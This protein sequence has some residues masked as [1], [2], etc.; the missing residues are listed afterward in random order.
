MRMTIN[1]EDIETRWLEIRNFRNLGPFC[2]SGKPKANDDKAFVKMNRAL[3]YDVLGGLI[4][5]IGVNNSGKSNVL[6]AFDCYRTQEFKDSDF[7]DFTLVDKPPKPYVGINL[8]N[9]KYRTV[10]EKEPVEYHGQWNATLFAFLLELDNYE[11]YQDYVDDENKTY[12]D[13]LEYLK[14]IV[15]PTFSSTNSSEFI[16]FIEYILKSRGDLDIIGIYLDNYYTNP[17]PNLSPYIRKPLESAELTIN[18]DVKIVSFG[19]LIREAVFDNKES[20]KDYYGVDYEEIKVKMEE[21]KQYVQTNSTH[22]P[23]TRITLNAGSSFEER[24][25]YDI[26]DNV[27]RYEQQ[28]IHSADLSCSPQ[29]PNGFFKTILE[30]TGFSLQVVENAYSGNAQLRHRLAKAIN[31]KLEEMSDEL[32]DL[33]N[34]KEKKYRL[35]IVLESNK[36]EFVIE[37]GDDIALNLDRQSQGFRWLFD[38][39]FNLLKSYEFRPGDI[40]LI[41]EFGDSLGFSTVEELTHKLRDYGR[42]NGITF[43]LATQNPMAIDIHHLDEVRLVLPNDNGSSEIFNE[44]DHFG[45]SEDH[46]ILKPLLNG[47][48]VSRNYMRTENRR[49]VFV[50][51]VTDYFYL[52]AFAEILR[53][54]NEDIDVDFI[55]IN[56][57]GGYKDSPKELIAEKLSIER[58]P[59]MF[60]DSD[61]KG[62][63][64]RKAV[65]KENNQ[66][67]TIVDIAEIFPGK[68]EIEDLFSKGD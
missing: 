46:D 62:K 19:T 54:Q 7:T 47:L 52:N 67:I 38:L 12:I 66:K 51:G 58:E 41:D 48:M 21:I 32:N 6:D 26:S 16:D 29:N 17:L 15:V 24:Y 37:Y 56:G 22:L 40:I 68:Q 45:E 27:Y 34:I 18:P 25:G 20:E 36:M 23:K 44:F 33:L 57:L 49:T 64:V 65:E 30:A 42:S 50:E 10:I 63:S 8:A 13:Y 1:Y 59:V 60:I 35:S 3:D 31:K 4:L 11:L 28:K 2:T 39:Y 14:T 61:G 5:L 43:V 55:P 9:G 53:Q